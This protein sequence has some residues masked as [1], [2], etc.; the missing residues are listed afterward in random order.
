MA[1]MVGFI[2]CCFSLVCAIGMILMDKRAEDNDK[3]ANQRGNVAQVG[4]EEK[5]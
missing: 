4:D 5:F 3:A 1:L 2:L